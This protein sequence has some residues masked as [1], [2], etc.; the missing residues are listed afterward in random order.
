MKFNKRALND[1]PIELWPIA[2]AI[3]FFIYEG[4]PMS[5]SQAPLVVS[6]SATGDFNKVI[7][8]LLNKGVI[9]EDY[10]SLNGFSMPREPIYVS[11]HEEV[12][13]FDVNQLRAFWS[14]KNLGKAGKMGDPEYIKK[15][16][17]KLMSDRGYSFNSI[18]A[19]GKKY[20]DQCKSDG[21]LIR[22]LSNFLED[23]L[24]GESMVAQYIEENDDAQESSY[25]P[26]DEFL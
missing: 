4:I 26:V 17:A 25:A 2:K 6:D 16:V 18:V 14:A 13:D 15:L 9:V 5:G 22:D 23:T 19:A 21:R 7:M 1:I 10:R 3:L 8:T 24:T 20:V 12:G 11:Y